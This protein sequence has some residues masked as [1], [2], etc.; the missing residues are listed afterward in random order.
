MAGHREMIWSPACER[1][2]FERA[3]VI[4]YQVMEDF[5]DITNIFYGGQDYEALYRGRESD[6]ET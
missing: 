2:P 3:A 6:S 5:V 1:V 4:T